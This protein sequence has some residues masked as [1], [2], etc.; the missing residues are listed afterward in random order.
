VSIRSKLHHP[1][2]ARRVRPIPPGVR[3]VPLRTDM[4]PDGWEALDP[5]WSER[6]RVTIDRALLQ[7]ADSLARGM[8]RREFLKKAGQASMV[9]GLAASGVL[10]STTSARAWSTPCNGCQNHPCGPSPIC[11]STYCDGNCKVGNSPYVR[12]RQYN[13]SNCCTDINSTC[14]NW[15]PEDCCSC[16]G[17]PG[18]VDWWVAKWRCHDC[19]APAGGKDCSP[20]SCG[21]RCICR[22]KT[23]TC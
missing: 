10:T 13:T 12:R 20:T 9:V 5:S 1:P 6:I 7:I 22:V 19:C 18:V 2:G 21:K 16:A 15:W 3:L 23:G 14:G 4:P 11:S 8:N 17:K